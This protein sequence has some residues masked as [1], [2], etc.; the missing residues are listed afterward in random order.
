MRLLRLLGLQEQLLPAPGIPRGVELVESSVVVGPSCPGVPQ[1]KVVEGRCGDY[2]ISGLLLVAIALPSA[3]VLV[4]VASEWQSS[5]SQRGWLILGFSFYIVTGLRYLWSVL[6]KLSEQILYLR[7]EVRRFA[8]PTLF[9]AITDVVAAEAEKSGGTC[10]FDQEAVQ[11]HDK[12]TG[13]ISV[14]FRFWSSQARRIAIAVGRQ[15]EEQG[16]PCEQ[17]K[18]QVHFQPGE[19]VVLGRDSRLERREILVL[20]ARTSPSQVLADKKLLIQWMEGTYTNFVKPVKDVVNIYALQESSAE[21]VPEWKFERVKPCK[22]ASS[23][24]QAFF[25]ERESLGKV[26]ADAKLWSASALRVYMITGPPG[27]GKS[28]FT[29]WIAGQLGLP[30]YR[31]SLTSRQLTDERLAQ[32]LSQSS[33]TFNSVLVQVDEFQAT[34]ERWMTSASVGVTPGGFCEVLQGSTAMS[35]GVVIL[36]GTGHIAAESVKCKLPA[37]FRRIHCIAELS[38]MSREDIGCYFRQFLARFVPGCTA[39]EWS[40]WETLFLEGSCWSGSR[41]ISIDML[42]QFLMHQITESSCQGHGDFVEAEVGLDAAV[43]QVS[44]EQRALFFA[45]VCDAQA[46]QSF[47][48]CYAPVHLQTHFKADEPSMADT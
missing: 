17:L 45:L 4:V 10:S 14:K 28:E 40:H 44:P 16:L 39:E 13:R 6:M 27:V 35:H 34:V 48:D 30:V 20:S 18:M 9:E 31:L 47:L 1:V 3:I 8:A 25:L 33:V 15:S 38:W 43:F 2:L 23:T 22:S 32:L 24:G 19:D 21:W 46:A 41:P 37:V 26:L 11:E 7:V 29:I 5:S 36:T 42:R 12:L